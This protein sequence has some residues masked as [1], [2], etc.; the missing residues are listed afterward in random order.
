MLIH[1]FYGHILIWN[2]VMPLGS[3]KEES[4]CNWLPEIPC[5]PLILCVL[6]NKMAAILVSESRRS[7]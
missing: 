2:D 7:L 6:L 1:S 3:C 5:N 4:D